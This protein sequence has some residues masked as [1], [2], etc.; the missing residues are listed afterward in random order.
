MGRPFTIQHEQFSDAMQQYLQ[1]YYMSVL[2]SNQE[3]YQAFLKYPKAS[4]PQLWEQMA[5]TLAR[6]SV[7]VKNYFFNTWVER[8][9]GESKPAKKQVSRSEESRSKSSETPAFVPFEFEF[10]PVFS[11]FD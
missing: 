4:R 5:V 3:I 9:S 6:S 11:I 10:A 7:Q 1:H 2:S 8:L